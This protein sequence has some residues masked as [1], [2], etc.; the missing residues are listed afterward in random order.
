VRFL[1][2][3]HC[4]CRS[5]PGAKRK[6]QEQGWSFD[7]DSSACAVGQSH[8]W[9]RKGIQCRRLAPL[10]DAITQNRR[11]NAAS[12]VIGDRRVRRAQA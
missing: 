2:N 3:W 4:V 7:D 6:D 9:I 12:A 1:C 11:V 10:G 5:K 8:G